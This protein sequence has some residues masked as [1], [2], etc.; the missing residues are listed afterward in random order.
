MKDTSQLVKKIFIKGEIQVLTGLMIGSSSAAMDIGGVDKMV[1]RHPITRLPYIPGSSIKGKLRSL[2]ELNL[3]QVGRDERGNTGP[4]HDPEHLPAQ[5]FGF[6]K[7]RQ[8]NR[9]SQQPSKVIIRDGELTNG[10]WL[11]GTELAYTEVKAENSIDRI[12]AA[13][14]P[15]FFERV[16]KGGVFNLEIILNV[17][18]SDEPKEQD[19]LNGLFHAMR[20][21]NDD[22]LGGGGSRG[23]GQVNVRLTSMEE[24]TLSYY[25]NESKSGSRDEE[26]PDGLKTDKLSYAE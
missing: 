11:Q 15:R 7:H 20:L 6:I 22:Y 26:I 17:F 18:D 1:I 23:N 24:R 10:D 16:P 4:T 5:L 19:L 13:A 3:G 9:K 8:N 14:N 12:T 21:L 2:L 25:R